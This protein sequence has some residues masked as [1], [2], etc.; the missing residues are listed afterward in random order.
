MVQVVGKHDEVPI[1]QGDR[2][3]KGKGD[4]DPNKKRRRSDKSLSASEA[5][6]AARRKKGQ[7]RRTC[8]FRFN[9]RGFEARKDAT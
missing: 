6:I 1:N 2:T 7:W 8:C 9:D 3:A 5:G 4:H